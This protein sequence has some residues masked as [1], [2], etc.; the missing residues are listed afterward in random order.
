[1]KTAIR[2]IASGLAA[3][4]A[5]VS[6]AKQEAMDN[7][8]TDSVGG[9]RTIEVSFANKT[10]KTTLEGLQPKFVANDVI[11]VSNGSAAEYCFVSI[12]G[13]G[14]A[15]ITTSLTGSLTMVYPA[16]AA[17]M[18]GNAIEGILVPTVQDG[19]FASANICKATIAEGAAEAQFANQTAV[20]RFYVDASIGV[21]S[22]KIEGTSNI[23]TDGTIIT[24]DPEGDDTLDKFS[25]DPGKRICYVAVLPVTESTDLTYTSVTTTQTT[26]PD[27]TVSRTVSSTTLAKNTMYNAFIPYYIKI[28][29]SDSPET[30]Q[31]WAYCN[32]GA[33]L[34]E[35][36]GEY[37]AWGETTGHKANS[38][39]TGFEDGHSFDWV[40]CPYQTQNTTSYSSTKFTKY[41]GS[42]SSSFKDQSATDAD[43][44]KTVLDPEDDAAHVNWHG[45]WRMPTSAEFPALYNATYWAWDATDKGYYV[46]KADATHTAGTRANSVPGDLN[47]ADA[48]LFFPAAGD[49]LNAS[50]SSAG[51][52]SSYWWSS[53]NLSDPSYAYSLLFSSSYV[54]PQSNY[55]RYYGLPVRPLSD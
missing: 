22:L 55:R 10:T 5:L 49:G 37:F 13:S 20:L 32:I 4:L 34:P 25:D 24:V 42:T 48:L 12:D 45:S 30:Y 27:N 43:A 39:K 35:D 8:N 14:N 2:I 11:K 26:Y 44:L 17:K 36:Y 54:I 6:C 15:S 46:F 18:N 3:S 16:A 52:G 41:L 40:N 53:L 9:A 7:G 1:M 47:K 19:K 29:V 28:K 50:L 51:S 33:F 31:K 23:A 38:A 21:K